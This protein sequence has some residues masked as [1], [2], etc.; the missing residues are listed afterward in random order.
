MLIFFLL[1]DKVDLYIIVKPMM[2]S[3]RTANTFF[4]L[5]NKKKSTLNSAGYNIELLFRVYMIL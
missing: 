4:L 1:L 2:C 5:K 3:L